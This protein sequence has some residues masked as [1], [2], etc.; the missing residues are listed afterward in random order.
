MPLKIDTLGKS[1]VLRDRVT[2]QGSQTLTLLHTKPYATPQI[3]AAF[4]SLAG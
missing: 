2:R 4:C 3:K 1:H